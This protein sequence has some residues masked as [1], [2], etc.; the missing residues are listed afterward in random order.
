MTGHDDGEVRA[1]SA[2]ARTG[3]LLEHLASALHGGPALLPLAAGAPGTAA[4]AAAALDEP[5][6]AG[7]ALLLTTSGSSGTPKVVELS[8]QALRASAAGTAA[9]LGGPAQWLLALP[10][11][12]VA[13]WQVLVRSVLAGTE[14]VVLPRGGTFSPAA[15]AAAAARMTG[16]RRA[17][18]LVPTQ[19][20]R[21]LADAGA[22]AAAATFDAVLVGGAATPPALLA[23][24][25]EAGVR[26][27]TTY[28]STETSGGCVY[29]GVPLPG[30]HLAVVDGCV[31]LGG[32]VLATR[33]RGEPALSAQ[34][35][36]H[37]AG[38]RWYHTPD[39]GRLVGGDVGDAGSDRDG[40]LGPPRL[41]VDGRRDDVLI[42]GGVNVS[43]AAVERVLTA[44]PGVAEAL[45]VGVEDAEWGQALTALVVPETPDVP[46]QLD[47]AG[48]RAAVTQRLGAASAPRSLLVVDALPVTALG[49]PDRRAASAVAS[50]EARRRGSG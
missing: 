8:A 43:P 42:T 44:L 48:V 7:A 40:A 9:V 15:F 30:V 29:D 36:V 24:A 23:A 2:D 35:F 5:V 32:E 16:G 17:T 45:V 20:R 14:P 47:L 25:R 31:H 46:D 18:A 41:V 39:V 37:R 12:H 6:D 26:V 10:L 3:D 27:V 4:R 33:Y 50:A 38:R 49:K 1:V 13:G 22:R 28:G 21:V 34:T 11:V 19:L